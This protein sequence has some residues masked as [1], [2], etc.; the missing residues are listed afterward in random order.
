MPPKYIYPPRPKSLMQPSQLAHEEGRGCWLWQH[1]FN[2]D[3]CVVVIDVGEKNRS[4]HLANRHGKFHP[5]SKFQ[6]LRQELCGSKLLLPKGLHYLDAEILDG[7]LSETIVLFDV[8]QIEKYLIGVSQEQ[9]IDLLTA[10]CGSPTELCY[11]GVALQV[12]PNIWMTQSGTKD[13]VQHFE[14]HIESPLIEGLVLKK[15]AS[16]LDN[17]GSKEYEVDWQIRCRKPAKNYRV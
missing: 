17:W 14:E 5:T 16:V 6:K 7:D 12:T 11:H 3:R 9:R 10:I 15:K 8:L 2:G 13:F 1:K 4:V